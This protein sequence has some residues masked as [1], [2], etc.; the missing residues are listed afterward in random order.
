MVDEYISLKEALHRPDRLALTWE[1]VPGRGVNA[2]NQKKV[3]EMAE[4]AV[5]DRLLHGITLTDSPG[6]KPS[7]LTYP[8]AA[9][10]KKSGIEPIVHYTCKDKNRSA[11]ESDLYALAG[12]GL[13]NLLVM[14]GDYPMDSVMGQAKPVFDLDSVQTLRL[15]ETLNQKEEAGFFAGAVVSPFKETEAE[16]MAQYYKLDKKIASGAQFIISQM[17]YDVKKMDELAQYM[18][19]KHPNVALIGNV[20]VLSLP[21][22][23]LMHANKIPGCVVSDAL[24]REIEAE[25]VLPGEKKERQ[26]LRAAKLYAVLKGL[27]YDGINI[28]GHGLHYQDV[29]QIIE[30][31]EALSADYQSLLPEFAYAKPGRF[32]LS[33]AQPTSGP[34]GEEAKGK[35]ARLK[36]FQWLHETVFAKEARCFPLIRRIMKQ[37]DDSSL[38]KPFTYFEFLVKGIANQCRF[39]GDCVLHELAFIC[40]MSSCPKQQRNGACGGSCEGWCEVFPGE[41]K[42]IYVSIYQ[43]Y[44]ATR[45]ERV[46]QERYFPPCNWRLYK[47]SSWLN[48]FR[49]LE[50]EENEK[51]EK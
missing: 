5:Q 1:M 11:I 30:Q 8:L 28:G 40:P 50:E 25:A 6:G 10:I 13:K 47:T 9:A 17:G 15:A 14:T 42:C 7:I 24:L 20:F 35:T 27:N 43:A 22:A 33:A 36:L 32:Y 45:E 3:L 21:A 41:R 2:P 38:E 16:T 51:R 19:K 49:Q 37:I 46:L 29:K 44:R 4:L 31:G 39:C 34:A 12:A 48:Y 18:R 26:L 23:R